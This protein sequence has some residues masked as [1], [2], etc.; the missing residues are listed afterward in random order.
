MTKVP[1]LVLSYDRP[2][3]TQEAMSRIAKYGPSRLYMSCDGPKQGETEDEVRV[4]QVRDV[5]TAPEWP[6]DLYTRFL[7]SNQ[8]LGHAVSGTLNLFFS[9]EA[10]GIIL[11]DDCLP[12]SDFF[13]WLNTC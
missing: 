11:E 9:Q 3:F 4:Q 1:V 2:D 5:L 13:G 8:G 12:S 7:P 6:M 10:E